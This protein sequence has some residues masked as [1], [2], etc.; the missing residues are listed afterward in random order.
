M[1]WLTNRDVSRMLNK[2]NS[3]CVC[4]V[5]ILSLVDNKIHTLS[6]KRN[7]LISLCKWEYIVFVDDDDN[8]SDDY[9][10]ELLK[11]TEQWTDVITF[12]V[13]IS[14]DWWEY[15]DVL[16]SKEYENETRD[17]IYYRRP[18]H[19]M[20]WRK[21][22]AI[23]YPYLNIPAEDTD[24]ANRAYKGIE[25]EYNIDKTLYYYDFSSVWSECL[26][27]EHYNPNRWR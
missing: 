15:K 5:E 12:K 16:Y 19:I 22:L 26:G 6:E 9:I 11:A 13:W 20:C 2:L 3:Q 10:K 17:D 18:N 4:D 25:T 1:C 23:Q 21:E 14:I 24:F 7:Q 8:I 27:T